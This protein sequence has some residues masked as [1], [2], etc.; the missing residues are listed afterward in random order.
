[1]KNRGL[2][3]AARTFVAVLALVLFTQGTAGAVELKQEWKDSPKV[4]WDELGANWEKNVH[5]YS[6]DLVSWGYKTPNYIKN[7]TSGKDDDGKKIEEDWGYKIFHV[8]F[9]KPNKILFTYK[10]SA[11]EN[12]EEGSVIDRAVAYVLRY[13][14]GTTFN[15]GHRGDDVAYIKFPYL[16]NKQFGSLPIPLTF[17]AAMKLLMIAS[18]SEIYQRNLDELKDCRGYAVN[19]LSIGVT[20]KKFDP[21]FKNLADKDYVV[22]AELSPRFGKDDYALD[23]KTGW[24]TLKKSSLSKPAEVIKLR[25]T[26]KN[27]TRNKGVDTIEAFIEPSTMMFVGIHEYEGDKLVYVTQFFN[28]KVNDSAVKDADWETF[29]KGRNINVDK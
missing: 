18:R 27:K 15:Y 17:K 8:N 23:E 5:T 13:T 22:S 9:L 26:D 6:T 28:M 10:Y 21:A 11:H 25:L 1:M 12:T 16:T 24:M 7:F 19:A 2:L 20:M 3:V 14:D 4:L 29:F